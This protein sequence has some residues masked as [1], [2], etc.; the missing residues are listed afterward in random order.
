VTCE[1]DLDVD[2]LNQAIAALVDRHESLRTS[3]RTH[4]GQPV[5]IVADVQ[6]L[7]MPVDDLSALSAEQ[8]DAEV[9][10][11]TKQH[12]QTPFDLETAPLFRVRLLRL[13][14]DT[15]QLLLTVHR[16]VCD[17]WS[18]RIL[19]QELAALY[20]DVGEG[21][22]SPL[23]PLTM[24]YADFTVW[25]FDRFTGDVLRQELAFWRQRLA[26]LSPE[27]ALPFDHS[28][29]AT[30]G[31]SG[32]FCPWDIESVL[33]ESLRG[34]G[35][36]EGA[37]L[38]ETLQAGLLVLLRRHTGQEDLVIGTPVGNR[39]SA[40][41]ESLVG[42]CRNILVLR[43]DV[44][45]DPT[46][47]QLLQRV[48]EVT[49]ACREHEE[50]PF[51]AILDQGLPAKRDPV[52]HPLV[53]VM[54]SLEEPLPELESAGLRLRPREVAPEASLM[55]LM[56]R[57]EESSHGLCGRFEYA[58][59]LFDS[60]TIARM[61]EQFTI[62]LQSICAQPDQPISRLPLLSENERQRILADWNRTQADF[63]RDKCIHELFETCVEQMPDTLAVDDGRRQVTYGELNC[64][65][66]RQAWRLIDEDV[67]PDMMVGICAD[68]SIEFVVGVLGILKANGAYV[69][70][71]PAYPQERLQAI[72]ADIRPS[73]ILVQ[74]DLQDQLPQTDAKVI[75]IEGDDADGS[76]RNENPQRVCSPNH[77]AYV[78]H[79]SGSTG[80]PKGVQIQHLGLVA[81][82]HW[83]QQARQLTRADR[84]SA[85][86]RPGFDQSVGE[87]FPCL[88]V[89]ASLHI[90]EEPVRTNPAAM[91]RWLAEKQITHA[92]L[93]TALVEAMFDEPWPNPMA[94]RSITV[95][96]EKLHRRPPAGMPFTLIDQY[97]PTEATVICTEAVVEPEGTTD[98][99]LHIGR[100]IANRQ[101]YILD[102]LLQ[103]VPTG[104]LGELYLGGVGLARGY[105]NLPEQT[106]MS[107]VAHPF[108]DTP[109]ARLYRTGDRCRFL[110]NGDIEYIGRTDFQVKIR[111]FRIELGEIESI[112]VQHPRVQEAVVLAR[113]D[114]A[115]EKYLA[116]YIV[117]EEA[118]DDGRP[119][120]ETPADDAD[121]T[122][123]FADLRTF[124]SAKLPSYMV[125]QRFV[126]L[127]E[128]PITPNGKVDRRALP[129]PSE[130]QRLD[131]SATYVAPRNDAERDLTTI[132]EEV[133]QVK[134]LGINDNFFEL[135]G[136]SLKAATLL[137]SI[138]SQLG[139]A[140]PLG[141]LFATPTVRGMA[142]ALQQ[143]LELGTDKSVVPLFGEGHHA[144][145]FLFAG[146][147]GHIFAYHK[148]ARLLGESQITYGVKAIGVDGN[149]EP[150]D[151]MEEIAAR[152]VEE[153]S[154]LHPKGP[155][156]LAGYSV[157]ALT[158]FEVALQLRALGRGVGFV[159]MFDAF[160]PGY[161]KPLPVAKRMW[162]HL[163]EFLG[164]SA[165]EKCTYAADRLRNVW[166]RVLMKLRL[167]IL[168]ATGV[169]E[170]EGLDQ[171]PLKRVHAALSRAGE[172]YWPSRQFDGKVVLFNAE[173]VE[174][175]PATV[176]DD[177]LFGWERWTTGP[178][179]RHIV[180]GGH[181]TLFNEE[182][183]ESLGETVKEC[184]LKFQADSS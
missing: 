174:E 21:S 161:P 120:G 144:P 79:T 114:Q 66:N 30:V 168:V 160:A 24:Q 53:Q 99:P 98:Q 17:R 7:N 97:G 33:V 57:L 43:T 28:R 137:A 35:E 29:P 147:G 118:S 13:A 124:V 38:F 138:Q 73:I 149:E 56:I 78:I 154:E 91:V 93:P 139:H 123:L 182:Y 153:I 113:E 112:L 72:A 6:A 10:R 95:A 25:Q 96:G 125:P 58:A 108:D 135:G 100:P 42:S 89:G 159:G 165:R 67:G 83:Y 140:L 181:M 82:A 109:G 156:L 150:P 163:K 49:K 119:R 105:L 76:E 111:G 46:Y 126:A 20:E 146:V 18:L 54:L 15:H 158:A 63:P 141:S 50:F 87:I 128:F 178:I 34:I 164:L 27:L 180:A 102:E 70:L 145:L 74:A 23:T 179:E 84:I 103:P 94:L 1:G 60:K 40:Q 47:R 177:P 9:A 130:Q 171:T 77:L 11:L 151:R 162:M 8:R 155:Y 80:K 31:Y 116:A 61:A 172:F 169:E 176:L 85:T 16:A 166:E 26:D 184:I 3:I 170:A 48:H 175:W 127:K 55:D 107:F 142:A 92:D 22:E 106:K 32:S 41:V 75:L 133:L 152:Y 104:V 68:R 101:A 134:P 45:G 4:E 5:Q 36:S 51:E 110:V 69:P 14:P 183:I 117:P 90:V 39:S 143:S 148:F 65:A 44:S 12:A 71:D 88:T 59:D 136:H 115:G 52:T 167:N 62:L 132:W 121:Q 131:R 86:S 81:F 157:G 2:H 64:R 19:C 122:A 37:T 173:E 129:A